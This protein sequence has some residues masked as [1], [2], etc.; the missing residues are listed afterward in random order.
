MKI[1]KICASKINQTRKLPILFYYVNVVILS[2]KY[3]ESCQTSK[4]KFFVELVNG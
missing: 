1:D 4:V 3:W 2:E